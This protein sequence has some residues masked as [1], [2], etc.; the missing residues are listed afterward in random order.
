MKIVPY[1]HV[2]GA[3]FGASPKKVSAI[4][5]TPEHTARRTNDRRLEVTFPR[6]VCR[7]DAR[8]R[9]VEVTACSDSFEIRGCRIGPKRGRTV[10][11]AQLGFAVGKLDPASFIVLG[12]IVSPRF[13]ITFD[14][15][16]PNYI[17]AFDRS[18]LSFWEKY[19]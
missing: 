14:P 17:T 13:G 18:E 10:P 15:D 11:F 19:V 5:G 16:Q 8:S 2:S 1:E 9:L 6:L 12:F 4:L 7:F 3:V